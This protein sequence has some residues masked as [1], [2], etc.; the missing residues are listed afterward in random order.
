MLLE[1]PSQISEVSEAPQDVTK[2][3][4]VPNDACRTHSRERPAETS[5]QMVR[6]F[7]PRGPPLSHRRVHV[8]YG[9]CGSAAADLLPHPSAS[10]SS[11]SSARILAPPA[12][13]KL[14]APAALPIASYSGSRTPGRY[15]QVSPVRAACNP[16]PALPLSVL[17][18]CSPAAGGQVQ[19]VSGG[20]TPLYASTPRGQPPATAASA[21]HATEPCKELQLGA[22]VEVTVKS[23][24][25]IKAP[26]MAHV[27]TVHANTSLTHRRPH[28]R[29]INGN[30]APLRSSSANAHVTLSP[31]RPGSQ[32]GARPGQNAPQPLVAAPHNSLK[33]RQSEE[34]HPRQ[35]TSRTMD[36][37]QRP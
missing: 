15:P 28:I 36:H 25:L 30:A 29:G 31:R 10:S 2:S 12:S 27:P 13:A 32:Q 21:R 20:T 37:L 22:G 1:W 17:G 34:V 8:S 33:A 18:A 26:V 16:V 6:P 9:E 11:A 4:A 19:P 23:D 14:L 24:P 7:T 5:L 3:C 35:D